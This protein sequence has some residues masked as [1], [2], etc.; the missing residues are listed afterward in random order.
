[1]LFMTFSLIIFFVHDRLVVTEDYLPKTEGISPVEQKSPLGMF[2]M[3]GIQG[4]R[5]AFAG[6]AERKERTPRATVDL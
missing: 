6:V 2:F 4:A 1:M 5:T 3:A